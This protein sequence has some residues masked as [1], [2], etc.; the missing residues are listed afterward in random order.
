MRIVASDQVRRFVQDHGGRLYVWTTSHRCCS[1]RLTL[2]DA[3]TRPPRG[4]TQDSDRIDA[5][6]FDLFLETGAHGL[7]RDLVLELR[8]RR[9][10]ISASWDGC[11]F[12]I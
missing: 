10:K 1:S 3:D 4:W 8:G 6:G 11:A 2:L 5:G 9:R 7:P 12:I